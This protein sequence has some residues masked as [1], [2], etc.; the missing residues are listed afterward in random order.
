M[1]L[2][3]NIAAESEMELSPLIVQQRKDIGIY[4]N[5]PIITHRDSDI[6][7]D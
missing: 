7:I 4:Y 3:L 1:E 6:T 2:F 5:S